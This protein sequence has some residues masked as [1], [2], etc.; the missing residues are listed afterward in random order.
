[1]RLIL[2]GNYKPDGQE[3]MQRF[4][5]MLFE[6]LKE[7]GLSVEC[8]V[9][10]AILGYVF[11]STSHGIGKWMGYIDKW[12]FFPVLLLVRR[13][14]LKRNAVHFHICDHSNAPYIQFLP[15]EKTVITCHDVIAIRAGLGYEG[16]HVS[17]SKMGQLLQKKIL[18]SLVQSERIAAVSKLT[19]NQLRELTD[20]PIAGINWK[21]IYNSFNATFFPL[22][23]NAS[24]KA[25]GKI[26]IATESFILHVGHNHPR[27]NK[28][29]LIEM[30][31][32]LGSKWNGKICFAG[33]PLESNL[34]Q[35]AG[36]LGVQHRIVSVVNPDHF[37]L[38]ALYSQCEA[39]IFPSFSE[40]FGWPI[41]E[42]QACGAPVITSAIEPM[43]E[44]GGDGALYA[45]PYSPESFAQ[46]FLELQDEAIR[47]DLVEK[48]L[49]NIR[50]FQPQ[51][52]IDAYL[53]LHGLKSHVSQTN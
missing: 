1:M 17:P 28:K 10:P 44:V 2:I 50:R 38:Q 15:R 11:S 51:S 31:A 23:E 48:G 18:H 24:R 47:N 52:M 6:G 39:F 45:D 20:K 21:V 27:K 36:R 53:S 13:F 29:L 5:N 22:E 32:C 41:I 26:G 19:L 40:G 16:T 46:A 30:T 4:T 8:W 14:T 35:L 42:A 33:K 49:Q 7:A 25:L 9:P 43:P 3:S 12:I 37:T 34:W